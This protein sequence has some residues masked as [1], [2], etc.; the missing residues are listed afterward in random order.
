LRQGSYYHRISKPPPAGRPFAGRRRDI[1]FAAMKTREFLE[2]VVAAALGAAGEEPPEVRRR[3]SLV[4]LSFGDFA[5]HYEVWVRPRAALIELGLHFEG[6]REDNYDR[7]ASLMGRMPE[8]AEALG[9]AVEAEEWTERWTRVHQTLPASA[10][11]EDLAIEA[12]LRIARFIEVLEPL[13]RPL[14]PVRPATTASRRARPVARRA[15]RSR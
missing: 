3:G 9:P 1:L 15:N 4:Q 10:L 2:L 8:I 13:L 12:G 7:I 5:Q 11:S 14:G 6:L